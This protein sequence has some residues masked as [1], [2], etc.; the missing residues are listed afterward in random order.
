MIRTPKAPLAVLLLSLPLFAQ[1]ATQD[2]LALGKMWTF[3]NPPLAY[4]EKE[5]GFKPDQKWLDSLRLGALRLGERENPW[6]S[7]SFVSPQGLIMTNHHCVREQVAQI[8][9]DNDWVKGGYA[10][11]KLEDEVKIPDLTV[12]QL[13]AQEDVTAKVGDGITASDDSTTV[14]QKREANI[15]KI[16]EEADKAHPEHMHQVVSLYQGAVYQLY[17]YR[18]Y[19]DIRLVLAVNLMAAHFG[20]DPDNFTYPRWSIDFSFVRA[21]ADDKPAD[22][23]ANYFRWRQ[24]GAK[25]NELVFVPGNP[26]QTN[27][28]LTTEQLLFQRDVEYPL[29]LEQLKNGIAILEPYAK[30]IPGILTTKLGWENSYKA[31]GGMLEG[32]KT[33][34]LMDLKSQHEKL[35]QAA[36]KADP[37]LD[38]KFGKVWTTLAELAQQKRALQPKVAFYAPSYSGVIERAVAMAK[39]FDTT[40]GEEERKKAREEALGMQVRGNQLTEALLI[41]HFARAEKWL[42]L[43]D[44]Y[45]AIVAAAS[46]TDG[47]V[48][49]KDS[50]KALGKSVMTKGRTVKQMLDAE[51]GAQQFAA[52]DDV[53]IAIGRV[54]WPLMRDTEKQQ[55]ALES[56]IA[57]QGTLVGQ[58][59]H[60]VYGANVSPDA[61]MT[62]RFSDGRVLGY[63]Y[64]GTLAPW[65]TSFYGLYGRTHEFGGVHPFDM[66]KQW[67]DAEPKIDMTKKV[68]FASTNDI[69][70]GNSG[71]CLVDKDLQVVG[72][73]F[74][75]NIES[76]PNDFYYTQ[77]RARAVSVH[78]DAIVEA[79]TKVYDMGRIAEELRGGK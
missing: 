48:V 63:E 64:N 21:Y 76:L 75:G 57:V 62:L 34:A 72:L 2:H 8:Q 66:A 41:D 65:A 22:T 5:Y 60:A 37:A 36:V 33:P 74:D 26:G 51:D 16:K 45:L 40:L 14:A 1:A 58:A 29:I 46:P 3:E 12:Q 15:A 10:A 43:K 38:A 59:L 55:K 50:L 42:T 20:G 44:P 52:S 31:I 73:I 17:R 13:I 56:A 67:V 70:G 11:T 9:G 39:S 32:L 79:L 6:C 19:D 69:V 71:S 7:A 47:P 24:E 28:Q 77:K 27:R 35:F 54:L 4:L 78:T 30:Q 61:T 49:W 25:E 53:G 23:S 18:V 68:C